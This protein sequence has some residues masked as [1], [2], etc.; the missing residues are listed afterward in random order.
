MKR[1]IALLLTIFFTT[2]ILHA[3]EVEKTSAKESILSK[4]SRDF[5][6]LQFTYEGWNKPD[7]I[8]TTGFGRGFNG[9][10]CYDF[11][12]AKSNFSFAAGI[13]IGTSNIY[14][15]KQEIALNDTG[16]S[17]QARFIPQTMDY[18]KY[19]VTAAYLEAPFELRFFG[20]KE[21][22]NRGFKAAIGL[23][24]GTLVGAH[25]KG[26][27]SVDGTKIID[28]E[29]SRR[30]LENWRF[31][32]TVRIGWGNVTLLGTYNLNNMYKANAGPPITP[33]SLG[34]CISGL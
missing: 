12:I 20:N 34:I 14:L 7:S 11:P 5:V 17:A 25:T 4:P 13:G 31:A 33:Y 3:Q 15:D 9:Y 29:D 21:N 32:G 24:I 23:R 30:F 27:R 16:S 26:R 19:K 2:T 22:R 6:M 10:I 18:K 28:K 8:R 1:G